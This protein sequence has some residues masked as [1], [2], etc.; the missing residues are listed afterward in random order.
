MLRRSCYLAALVALVFSLAL[1]RADEDKGGG[2]VVDK[3]NKRI[4]V[5]CKVAPRQLPKFK[6]VY[7]LEVVACWPSPKG[8]KAHETLVVLDEKIKP[9]DV[10]KALEKI[11]LKAGKPA[12]GETGTATGAEVMILLEVPVSG[13][14]TGPVRIEDLMTDTKTNT[15]LPP[16]KWFFTGSAI[17]F[18]DPE[19]DDKAYGADLTGTFITI[20]PV[21]DDTVFQSNLGKKDEGKWRLE[22]NKKKLPKEGT[23][24]KLIIQGR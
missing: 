12:L 20:F 11:G 7:P 18:P 8:Q 22:A 14:K 1:T 2:I 3:E 17:K 6:Q 15:T 21:T 13:D 5:P 10:H 23:A 16:A 9:S 19:K 4:E 24:V